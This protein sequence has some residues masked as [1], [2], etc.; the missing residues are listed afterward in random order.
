M[1]KRKLAALV[2]VLTAAA[3]LVGAVC[4]FSPRTAQATV[5]LNQKTGITLQTLWD[6]LVEDG[7]LHLDTGD[8]QDQTGLYRNL[9]DSTWWWRQWMKGPKEQL[10]TETERN[11]EQN[12]LLFSG[13]DEDAKQIDLICAGYEGDLKILLKQFQSSPLASVSKVRVTVESVRFNGESGFVDAPV[14]RQSYVTGTEKDTFVLKLK[15]TAEYDLYHVTIAPAGTSANDYMNERLPVR[16]EAQDAK[17]TGN[18]RHIEGEKGVVLATGIDSGSSAA[19]SVKVSQSGT[20][21]FNIVYGN[22]SQNT[23]G[24]PAYASQYLLVNGEEQIK[25]NYAPTGQYDGLSNTGTTLE[26]EKGTH[27]VALRGTDTAGSVLIACMDVTLLYSIQEEAPPKVYQGIQDSA[28]TTDNAAAFFL[29]APGDGYYNMTFYTA[30]NTDE[31]IVYK[32]NDADAGVLALDD[33]GEAT[34]T[35][36]LRKGVNSVI[37]PHKTQNLIKSVLLTV[38]DT[39]PVIVPED[40]VLSPALDT[41]VLEGGAQMAQAANPA[42]TRFIDLSGAGKRAVFQIYAQTQGTYWL[43]LGYAAYSAAGIQ[44]YLHAAVN[45]NTQTLFCPDSSSMDSFYTV[46]VLVELNAGENTVAFWGEDTESQGLAL[47]KISVSK[48]C[49][50]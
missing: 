8:S 49:I 41:G 26:L 22:H 44:A 42:A 5:N 43:T 46:T 9:P 17:L 25:L 13:I 35:V 34:T 30:V 38:L 37:A 19:F 6:Q 40:A 10:A 16:Y 12:S 4:L 29:I 24:Q 11:A 14:V 20:Y 2:I 47:S 33:G 32:I 39:Q 31:T 50:D 36:Y 3:L 28:A 23:A 15:G 45:G 21:R 1:R 48:K 7:I 18:A 27:T